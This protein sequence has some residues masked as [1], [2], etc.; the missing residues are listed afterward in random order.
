[1]APAY[2]DDEEDRLADIP[3]LTDDEADS[4]P[5]S[6]DFHIRSASETPETS[7]TALPIP[8]WLRE[9]ANTFKYKWVPLPI[10]KTSRALVKWVK[11]PV[12]PRVLRID[13]IFPKLQR[14]PIALLD[15]YTPK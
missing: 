15:K 9:S 5:E 6:R 8:I 14:A 4:L 13:P 10:R 2:R 1:M 11:G 3:A 12:P 7:E